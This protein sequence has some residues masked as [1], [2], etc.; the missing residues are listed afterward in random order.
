MGKDWFP[1]TYNQNTTKDNQRPS[2][3]K[4]GSSHIYFVIGDYSSTGHMTGGPQSVSKRSTLIVWLSPTI[5]CRSL[6]I[7]DQPPTIARWSPPKSLTVL[8]Q[9]FANPSNLYRLLPTGR[10]LVGNR[11]VV[12]DRWLVTN[13]WWSPTAKDQWNLLPTDDHYLL[14]SLPISL[15]NVN[16]TVQTSVIG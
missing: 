7:G 12:T 3:M 2:A 16:W 11:G 8:Q 13:N 9:V 10:W 14:A 1:T 6:S 5:A 15:I 4:M